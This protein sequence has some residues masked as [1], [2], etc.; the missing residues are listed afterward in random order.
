MNWFKN[1]KEKETMTISEIVKEVNRINETDNYV[2]QGTVEELSKVKDKRRIEWFEK[3]KE[4]NPFKYE[5]GFKVLQWVVFR[6]HHYIEW[7][8]GYGCSYNI[9][10]YPTNKYDI[11]NFNNGDLKEVDE[12]F[13]ND[14]VTTNN[15]IK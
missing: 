9:N 5:I 6:K 10:C 14:L 8:A 1:K 15:A 11:I 12:E 2:I 13:I 3:W 4:N 7:W